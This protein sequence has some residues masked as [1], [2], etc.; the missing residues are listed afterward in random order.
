MKGP[1]ILLM[2]LAVILITVPPGMA[3]TSPSL[4]GV[5]LFPKDDVWNVPV[6]TLPVDAKSSLYVNS[7]PSSR[8]YM[9]DGFPYNVADASTPRQYLKSIDT[10]IYSDNIRYPIPANAVIQTQADHHLLIVDKS[11]NSLYEMYHARKNSDGT[12]SAGVAVAYDLSSYKLRPDHTV[13]ADAA[14]LPMLQGVVRYEEVASGSVNH[15]LRFAVNNLRNT[16]IWPARAAAGS[17]NSDSSLPPHGQRFRLKASFDTSGF[18]AQEKIILEALKKYG[19]ILA[20][21][22]GGDSSNFHICADPDSRWDVDYS[23]LQNIRLTDFEAVDE[24]SIMINKDSSQARTSGTAPTPS[25]TS[26][27]QP[28]AQFTANITQGKAPL[29]VQ[30]TDQSASAGTTTYTWDMT[31]DGV[32]ESTARNPVYTYQKA[33]NYTVKHTVTNTSGSDSE[34]K[35]AYIKVTDPLSVTGAVLVSSITVTSPNGGESFVR[36]TTNR[37]T[38]SSAGSPGSAVKIELLKGSTVVQTLQSST[39]NDGSYS[40]WTVSSSL[41]TGSDYRIRVTSTTDPAITDTSNTYFTIT[42]SSDSTITVTSPNGGESFVRGTTNRI[43]WSSAGS[44]GSAV[45]IE[46]LKGSTVVQTLQSSTEN[47]GSYSSW[48]VSSSLATGSDYRIRVTSTTDPAITDTS[49]T[50]FT[51]TG[52]ST[53][54]I[55]VTSPNGGQIWQRG[56]SQTITWDY[57]GTPGSAVKIVL[58]KAGTEVGTIKDSVSVGSNGKGSY[59]WPMALG[60]T[61]GSDFKVS[62]QSISQPAIKDLSNNYFTITPGTT[63]TTPT[64]TVTSP[65]G[66]QTWKRGTT[67]TITWDYTGTPGSTVKIV[68]LKAGTEVGTIKDS[69]SVGSSGKGSY[70]WTMAL[71]YMTGSDFKV[72]VQSISQ[73]AIKDLSNNYF[74]ITS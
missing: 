27:S 55:T 44:P 5:Q 10:P 41:A 36:G 66:G 9:W 6:N 12:Y 73:P 25:P 40:S 30:F 38:W 68:L 19:M 26:A 69:V 56:T 46:L 18:N 50:Y 1:I 59:T 4:S 64:I 35:T 7:N 58:L 3:A 49:N 61:T 51:I 21:W 48:T 62:V 52:S 13:S 71:G 65:N 60:Y 63:T 43:T 42:G 32:V 33:G 37:I 15:A 34:I 24:S 54:T 17:S 45:K 70:S 22:N 11:T 74:T 8:L 29:T 2:A 39:E 72:S 57:T 53:S 23:R 20:D 67:Q 47:D 14:G 16:Y 28:T 31:N